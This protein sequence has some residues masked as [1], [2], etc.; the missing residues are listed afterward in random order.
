MSLGAAAFFAIPAGVIALRDAP[1]IGLMLCGTIA[2]VVFG[3]LVWGSRIG[4]F[5]MFHFFSAGIALVATPIAAI[6]IRAL[7]QR[8]QALAWRPVAIGLFAACAIQLG[9]GIVVTPLRLDQ[10][11]GKFEPWSTDLL[12]SIRAL[13]RDAKLAYACNPLEELSYWN[14]QLISL[15]AHA[16]IVRRTRRS[17]GLNQCLKA[18]CIP[19]VTPGLPRLTSLHS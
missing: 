16:G 13:P 6:A 19:T 15:D 12:A 3:A 2:A 8:A 18:S 14:S 4:T 11:K 1:L 17:P 7:W 5:T 10:G 9:V